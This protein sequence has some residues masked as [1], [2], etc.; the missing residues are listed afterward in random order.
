[1][2]CGRCGKEIPEDVEF[3]PHCG[4]RIT[5]T[6]KIE[7]GR[8]RVKVNKK[9]LI[10][11]II[12]VILIICFAI[13]RHESD[14]PKTIDLNKYVVVKVSGENGK[15]SVDVSLD[16]EKLVGEF[17]EKC[18]LEDGTRVDS[19]Q[20]SSIKGY[21]YRHFTHTIGLIK[22]SEDRNLSNGDEITIY[23]DTL[24]R[25]GPELE[26]DIKRMFDIDVEYSDFTYKVSGLD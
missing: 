5:E 12:A 9:L 21:H 14:K 26:E 8:G 11:G 1:M 19:I 3:C 15:G 7:G 16:D 4:S 2:F 22:A 24:N 13:G 10:A 18:T 25:V 6:H 23:W 20:K 17:L